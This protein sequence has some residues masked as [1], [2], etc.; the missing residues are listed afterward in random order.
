MKIRIPRWA[1]EVGVKVNGKMI[2][3]KNRD[4]YLKLEKLWKIGDLVE[5]TLPMYLRK[6]YVPNCSDK[7]AFFY[8]PVLL[9]GRL[10]DAGMPDQVFARRE[11]DYTRTNLYEYK[12]NFLF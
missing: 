10:G 11:N 4:G 6:E 5:L 8:G 9:A 3:Y 2:K 7:F 12:G 1:K